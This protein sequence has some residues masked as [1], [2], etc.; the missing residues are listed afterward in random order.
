[1]QNKILILPSYPL[2]KSIMQT[3]MRGH[4]TTHL[5]KM[6][7]DTYAIVQMLQKS[8]SDAGAPAEAGFSSS[9]TP[10]FG[11]IKCEYN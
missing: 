11:N 1:M 9:F 8:P 10:N 2:K 7:A 5:R 4:I 6:I 3:R